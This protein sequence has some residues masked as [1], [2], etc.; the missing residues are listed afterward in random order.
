MKYLIFRF[1]ITWHHLASLYFSGFA[2]EKAP[3]HAPLHVL[4]LLKR[5]G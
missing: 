1:G 4:G 2:N 5:G 3:K